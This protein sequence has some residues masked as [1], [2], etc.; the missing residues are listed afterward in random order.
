MESKMDQTSCLVDLDFVNSFTTVDEM[1]KFIIEEKRECIPYLKK[2][3][4]DGKLSKSVLDYLLVYSN[5]EEDAKY[6]LSCGAN[7]TANDS[8]CILGPAEWASFE[9][10]KTLVLAGAKPTLKHLK[11]AMIHNPDKQIAHYFIDIMIDTVD[12]KES[13][14]Y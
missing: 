5:D 13:I 9:H 1:M 8:A 7:P 12:E 14:V 4:K 2:L 3:A 6:Y 11:G 10:I